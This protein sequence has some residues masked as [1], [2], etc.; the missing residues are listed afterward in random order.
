MARFEPIVPAGL[1]QLYTT[2][3]HSPG[4]RVNNL[5]FISGMLGR[6][7]ELNVIADPEAQLVQMFENMGMVLAEA[8]C[9]WTDV[10]ELTGYF[11]NW[12]RDYPLF[13][14]VRNRYI[15]EPHPAMTMIGIAE[16]ARPGLICELKGAAVIPD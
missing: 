12:Q 10:F 13:L 4:V 9:V 15:R 6:D 7:S 3:S 8:G 1:K 11:I 16:L 2:R 5:L 14:E